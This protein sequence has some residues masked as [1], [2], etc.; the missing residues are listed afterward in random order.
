MRRLSDVL[1]SVASQLGLE[2]ELELGRAYASWE[3]LVGELVPAAAGATQL[4]EIRPPALIVS[5][6]DGFVA[7]ELRLNSDELLRAFAGAPGGT[8]LLELRPVVR[9]LPEGP[10]R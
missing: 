3:R 2:Q 5:A 4:L 10:S 9:R 6:S 7:Q 8:R 1:P